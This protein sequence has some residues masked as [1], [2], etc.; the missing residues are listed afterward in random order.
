MIACGRWATLKRALRRP[1]DMVARYGGEEF[2]CL[3]PDTAFE[4]A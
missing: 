2:V 1:T 4:D 3:L